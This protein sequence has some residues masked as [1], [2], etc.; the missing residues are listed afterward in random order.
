MDGAEAEVHAFHAFAREDWRKI[1]STNALERVNN[2]IERR[3]RVAGVFPDP[4]A[5]TDQ[6]Y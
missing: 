6:R 5:A 2:E 1:W 3:S 4:A